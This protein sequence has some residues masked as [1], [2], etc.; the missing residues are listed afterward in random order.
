MKRRT[1]PVVE[2]TYFAGD[3]RWM[4]LPRQERQLCGFCKTKTHCFDLRA[5]RFDWVDRSGP[6]TPYYA[7]EVCF[8]RGRMRVNHFTDAGILDEH[9]LRRI[10]DH[11][12]YQVASD[13]AFSA[14]A[15]DDLRRTPE[16]VTNQG[17]TWLVHCNDFMVYLGEWLSSDFVDHSPTGDG[18][19]LFKSMTEPRL[20]NADFWHELVEVGEY[21]LDC[22]NANYYAFQCRHCQS[23]RGYWDMS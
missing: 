8:R 16:F 13:H 7:C 1:N 18:A 20:S 17:S 22:W 12:L 2:Y 5:A 4:C 19:A 9:G 21:R 10:D 11:G 3:R 6:I 23:L 14:A 15:M